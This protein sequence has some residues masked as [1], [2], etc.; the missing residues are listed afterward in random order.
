MDNYWRKQG[1]KALFPE[2]EWNRPE[3]K[4]LAGLLA[5]FGGNKLNFAAVSQGYMR[6]VEMGIGQARVFLP[7]SVRNVIK[8]RQIINSPQVFFAKSGPSGSFSAES[9]DELRAAT[10]W[11]KVSLFLG[12]LGKNAETEVVIERVLARSVAAEQRTVIARDAVDIFIASAADLIV[13]PNLVVIASFAQLQKVFRSL[14]Y[15][16]ILTFSLNLANLVEILHKFTITYP[17]AIATLHQD[18]FIVARG[19]TVISTPLSAT[20][21]SPLSI[22]SGEVAVRAAVFYAWNPSKPLEATATS[23]MHSN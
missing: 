8:S 14:F 18:S 11:A 5:I 10:D 19:G 16:K 21:Y 23:I 22:W 13:N 3:Q 2:I 15:P 4:G 6:A 1:E 17:C 7:D 12:D 9:Y 20:K